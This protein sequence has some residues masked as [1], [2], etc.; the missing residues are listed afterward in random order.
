MLSAFRVHFP[1][2]PWWIKNLNLNLITFCCLVLSCFGRQSKGESAIILSD[3]DLWRTHVICFR[4]S[5]SSIHLAGEKGREIRGGG[6]GGGGGWRGNS[7]TQWLSERLALNKNRGVASSVII[8][9]SQFSPSFFRAIQQ[10]LIM[11]SLPF[12]SVLLNCES[13]LYFS[14]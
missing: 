11:L 7:V 12:L 2:K 10:V 6:G 9:R 1:C 13:D 8:L 5:L 14:F 3:S 4:I